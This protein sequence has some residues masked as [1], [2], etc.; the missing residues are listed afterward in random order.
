MPRLGP[1][2]TRATTSTT[3][4]VR[5]TARAV[6]HGDRLRGAAR[7]VRHGDRLRG[8]ARAVRHDDRLRGTARAVRHDD[9]LRG[10][11]R[12]VR[13]D[14]KSFPGAA[15]HNIA[16]NGTAGSPGNS[17]TAMQCS[18]HCTEPRSWHELQQPFL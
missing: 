18:S 8:T 15:G 9:R 2:L 6:R 13:H 7:A 4:P 16:T 1:T 12:A 3:S 5:G 17:E 10:T 11:A 14:D